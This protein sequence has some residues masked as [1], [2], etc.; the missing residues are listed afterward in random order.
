MI[1]I[2]WGPVNVQIFLDRSERPKDIVIP[3]ATPLA[4]LQIDGQIGHTEWMLQ[5]IEEL[6]NWVIEERRRVQGGT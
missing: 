4:W 3:R 1:F 2:L 5:S 6:T